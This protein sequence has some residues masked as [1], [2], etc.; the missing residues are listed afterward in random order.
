MTWLALDIGGANLKAADGKGWAQ[1]VPFALWRDPNGLSDAL[2]A[3]IASGPAADRLAV[4]MTGELCDCF[5]TKTEGVHHIV[6]SAERAAGRCARDVRVYLVDGRLVAPAEARDSPQL[7]SASN[8]HALARFA[9]RFLTDGVG[10]LI[11]V[12]ST[13]TDVIPLVDGK[14]AASGRTDTERLLFGELIY[15]GVARTPI[16]AVVK[17]LP[18]GGRECSVAAELFAT[19]ADAYMLLGEFSED[20]LANW[21][22]DGRP[23]TKA[24]SLQRLARQVCA[25]ALD[26][27]ADDIVQMAKAVRDTQLAE[28]NRGLQTVGDRL[29]ERPTACIVSGSGEFLARAAASAVFHECRVI[30]LAQEIGHGASHCAPA[31]ALAAL[32]GEMLGNGL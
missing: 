7:V 8:W 10:V 27:S 18:L 13:T 11:D 17:S 26:L 19:T 29:P 14:V 20:A 31:H 15:R 12:G 1:S 16:C 24:N 32:A 25:D 4:T 28:L 23:L 22:A 21:T 6:A 30:S 5:R 3:L 9:C 2:A